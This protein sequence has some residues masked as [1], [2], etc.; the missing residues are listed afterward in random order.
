MQLNYPKVH[1]DKNKCV[2]V[3]FY[4][5]NK[6]YRLYSGKRIGYD[7]NP[8]YHPLNERFAVGHLLAAKVYDYLTKGGKLEAYRSNL[9]LSGMLT[10]KECLK[11][12]LEV[13]YKGDYSD[14]YKRLLSGIYKAI[15]DNMQGENLTSKHLN[16]YLGKYSTGVSFNTIRRHLNV[17]INEAVKQGMS[18][19]PM[20]E[21]KARKAKAILHKPFDDIKSVIE[22]TKVFNHN[23]HLCC[24]I[25][26]GCLL[27]P[28]RE[29]RELCWADFSEDLTS[30]NL[31]GHRNKSGRN[32]IVPV[33]KYIRDYLVKGEPLNNIFTGRPKA[34]NE[35]YFKT[36][37]S[38]Y[39]KQSKLIDNRHTLYSF[40][41]SGA[42]DIFKRTGSLAK[43][44]KA[45][46]HSSMNVSLTYLRGLEIGDLKEEDMPILFF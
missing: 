40:R 4:I 15:T 30:I 35:D 3:S 44:Q 41:H 2:F 9:L 23:L 29:I 38:R 26:Y 45:M 10:D 6:R 12:A 39:K 37:W 22:E 33:P 24:L 19:N 14:K 1:T 43:L 36:L 25:T 20:K 34:F 13:K 46:G 21:I 16:N 32:R 28:H 7:I 11:R 27:R 42:I 18:H 8:N 17:L 31:S 5:N